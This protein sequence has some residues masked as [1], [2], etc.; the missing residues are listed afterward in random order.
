[1]IN[2]K[3]QDLLGKKGIPWNKPIG[4]GGGVGGVGNVVSVF[5]L[6]NSRLHSANADVI[7][8]MKSK[9]TVSC[10]HIFVDVVF[11]ATSKVPNYQ[12]KT[13]EKS[14]YPNKSV[15]TIYFMEF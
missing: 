1:M 8:D 4:R 7:A 14:L 2:E 11:S 6:S 3:Q 9:I 5:S 10:R 13:G 15:L 12:Y